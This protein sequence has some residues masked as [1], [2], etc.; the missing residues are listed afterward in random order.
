MILT[1]K[2]FKLRI[3]GYD[4]LNNSECINYKE[5]GYGSETHYWY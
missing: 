1:S 4:D 5:I 2:S 3:S